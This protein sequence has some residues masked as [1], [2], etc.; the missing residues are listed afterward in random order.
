MLSLLPENPLAYFVDRLKTGLADPVCRICHVYLPAAQS[1][2]VCEGCAGR[3]ALRPPR[4]VTVLPAGELHAACRFPSGL[5]RMIYGLKFYGE[6]QYAAALG[7]LM[8]LYWSRL[9]GESTEVP[10]L[11][12]PVPPHEGKTQHPVGMIAREFARH[13]GYR[14]MPEALTWGREVLPQH[15]LPHRRDREQNLSQAFAVSPILEKKRPR[16]AGILVLDDILT[17]GTTLSE[18]ILT[19]SAQ[20]PGIPVRGLA[21]A[22]V[23]LAI[24]TD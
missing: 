1:I 5:K 21:I 2:R 4:P 14:L 13:F 24:R 23:P 19:L 3:L 6:T 7:E 11:V 12:A 8:A 18:A 17:T 10:W 15:Q 20:Y 22:H 16:R 9:P